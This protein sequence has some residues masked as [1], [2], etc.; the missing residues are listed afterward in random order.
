MDPSQL[1]EFRRI[2]KDDP[3]LEEIFRLRYKVYVEEWGFERPEDHQ[4]GI[5]MDEFDP[6][7]IHMV[8]LLRETQQLIGTIRLILASDL[9]F[10]IE[11]HCTLT[12][13]M[14]GIPRQSIGEISRLAVSKEFRKRVE[15]RL[16]YDQGETADELLKAP[17]D[18]RRRNE[19]AIITGLYTALYRESLYVGLTHWYCVMA[20]GL[21]TL[22]KRFRIDFTAIG[23]RVNYHG[24]RTPYIG[25]IEQIAST[26]TSQCP[27]FFRSNPSASY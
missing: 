10:P 25:R 4:G 17:P 19:Y 6:H 26:V 23:P 13:D 1:F 16:I 20:K 9:G 22:L 8:A 11:Q 7:S 3:R 12:T 2:S 5:E 14:S 21:S 18:E 15:D 27:E 24:L